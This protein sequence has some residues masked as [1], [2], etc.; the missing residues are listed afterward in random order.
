[1]DIQRTRAEYGGFL[2]LELN[3]GNEYF[4]K[5]QEYLHRFNSVKAALNFLIKWLDLKRVYVPYYYC[6]STTEAIQR[7]G[8]EVRFYHID[9]ELMPVDLPDEHESVVL[10]VDYFGV[11]SEQIKKLVCTFRESE[12]IIDMAHAFYAEP[13]IADHV[14]NVYSAK[15]FFGVP[16]GAY[17]VSKA[18][19]PSIELPTE[20]HG[21]AEYLLTAYEE[22]TNAAYKMKK[23][24]DGLIAADYKCMSRLA[25][26]LLRNV[27]YDRV[28]HQ[29]INNYNILYETFLGVNELVLP[30][31]C[32]AYQ[33]PLLI[34]N[35]GK[36]I[37]QQ[38]I[39]KQIFV[40]TLWSGINL[41]ENGNAFELNMMDNAI[42]LPIDQRYSTDD[43]NYIISEV[44]NF[45][46]NDF[47]EG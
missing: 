38:L 30:E 18:V 15:K 33:F 3:L 12:V 29:R 46:E 36:V 23:E 5:Y 1:M 28:R 17:L 11:R 4:S 24:V 2:P 9:K 45:L 14:H 43:M 37:K 13:L 42:F 35:R 32:V 20:A 10:L 22:G 31:K 27:D 16:D 25:I 26:G 40:S 44:K 41:L 7:M 8:I 39:E 6:P 34:S 21:Y 47:D 19:D